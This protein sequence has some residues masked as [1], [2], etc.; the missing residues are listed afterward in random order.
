MEDPQRLEEERRLLFVGITRAMEE[1]E[2]SYAQYRMFRGRSCPTVPSKFLMELPRKEMQVSDMLGGLRMTRDRYEESQLRDDDDDFAGDHADDFSQ[3][4]PEEKKR[5]PA[6][7]G[8]APL[9]TAADLL[10]EQPMTQRTA[11][12]RFHQGMAVTHPE[13]GP[14]LIVALSGQGVKRAATIRFFRGGKE[15]KFLLAH[16]NLSPVG[17]DDN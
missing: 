1:L 5:K 17:D 15:K 13:Y 6:V 11:V 2:L 12:D 4:P 3:L 16:A 10:A 8:L 14:G 7:A 9:V